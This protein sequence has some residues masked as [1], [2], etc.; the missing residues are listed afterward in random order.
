MEL[1]YWLLLFI[2]CSACKSEKHTDIAPLQSIQE[3]RDNISTTTLPFDKSLWLEKNEDRYTHRVNMYKPL[4]FDGQLK[5]LS[6]DSIYTMLGEPDRVDNGHLFYLISQR[7]A[8]LIIL[9]TTTMVIKLN[10]QE[11]V[12]WVKIH[13]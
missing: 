5:G 7:R 12:D 4:V 8:G 1:K 9:H 2:A 10:D 3:A 13:E 11:S 6:K